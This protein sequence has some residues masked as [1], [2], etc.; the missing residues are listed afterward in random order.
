[1]YTVIGSVNLTEY[2]FSYSSISISNHVLF[3]SLYS[4]LYFTNILRFLVSIMS[5]FNQFQ[6]F[7]M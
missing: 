5:C 4:F 7:S 1:M 2:A 6:V 3:Y